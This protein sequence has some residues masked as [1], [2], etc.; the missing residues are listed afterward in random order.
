METLTTVCFIKPYLNHV[1]RCTGSRQ[2]FMKWARVK[3][4]QIYKIIVDLKKCPSWYMRY[5]VWLYQLKFKYFPF[6]H[7]YTFTCFNFWVSIDL[8]RTIEHSL[9]APPFVNALD[10][11]LWDCFMFSNNTGLIPEVGTTAE[12]SVQL[13][14]LQVQGSTS[15][16][17]KNVENNA[18]NGYRSGEN[19]AENGDR[20]GENNAE[21]ENRSGENESNSVLSFIKMEQIRNT[22]TQKTAVLNE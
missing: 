10:I 3:T 16:G 12:I 21:N 7:D 14:K 18:E 8:S 15:N 11:R 19:N 17:D 1:Y 6:L 20:S 5:L 13:H 9:Y 4:N 22:I 2:G